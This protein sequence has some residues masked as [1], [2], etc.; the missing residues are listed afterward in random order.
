MYPKQRLNVLLPAQSFRI[1]IFQNI[2]V[3]AQPERKTVIRGNAPA[4]RAV[5]RQLFPA[6]IFC[7]LFLIQICDVRKIFAADSQCE[8]VRGLKTIPLTLAQKQPRAEN[9]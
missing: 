1:V 6:Q 8:R 3:F 4:A 5:R 7:N 9:F 2:P